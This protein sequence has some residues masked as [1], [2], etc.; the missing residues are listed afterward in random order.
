MK[1][2]TVIN[3]ASNKITRAAHILY[4]GDS[5]LALEKIIELREFL[6]E[7]IEPEAKPNSEEENDPE[8]NPG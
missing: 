6:N 7:P 4:A 1:L 8:Y 3:E 2:G 5:Y